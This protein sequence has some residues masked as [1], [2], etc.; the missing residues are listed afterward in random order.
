MQI[1]ITWDFNVAAG[2]QN[3]H[4]YLNGNELPLSSQVSR[5]PQP[6]PA[7]K[8]QADLYGARIPP[9]YPGQRRLRRLPNLESVI[10]P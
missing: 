1:R 9:R 7:E 10:A 3:L 2:Q 6:V 5:G 8:T 4:L